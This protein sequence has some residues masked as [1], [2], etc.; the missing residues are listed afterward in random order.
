MRNMARSVTDWL[1]A[2]AMISVLVGCAPKDSDEKTTDSSVA[3][4][5][6][7]DVARSAKIPVTSA[8]DE[9]RSLYVKGRDLSE[10]LRNQDA[11]PLFEQAVAKD[12]TFALAHYNLALTAPT[13]K[14]FL[15]HLGQAVA[16][17]SKASEGE[18][19]LIRSLEAQ[20]KADPAKS[21]QLREEMVA[22]YPQDERAH[23]NLGNTYNGRQQYDKAV[24]EYRKAIELN[25]NFSPAY[26]SLGYTYRP[27]GNNTEAEQA[28]R[29]YIELVPNDPNPYDS[30]AELLMK[31]GRFDESIAQYR[32]A[33]SIDPRFGA[34]QIGIASN[35][36]LQG[37]H[38][39]AIAEAQKL[40][41]AARDDGD[42]RTAM[43]T[44]V[45]IDVDRGRT[46]QALQRMERLYALGA[47]SADT[48][49][50]ANDAAAIG[51][52]L[53]DA[54][55]TAEAQK[56]YAQSLAL[57]TAS[58]FPA[59]VKEDARL[60]DHF[61]KARVALA[62]NDLE[63][64]KAEADAYLKGSEAKQ[65]E[66]RVRGAHELAGLIAQKEKKFDEAIAHYGKGNQQ[67]PFVI[68][69][70]AL[71]HQGKG[72]GAKAKELSQ[73]AANDNSLPGLNYAFV[74]TKARNL[75]R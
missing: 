55:R 39:E 4:A 71:A 15:E 44:Q 21:L 26:N 31:M 69:Q 16:H 11:R 30:Y 24:A 60:G 35:L 23:F 37:K 50:M 19:L 1:P 67:D 8:S 41:D 36:M 34:S 32:K 59:E 51:D 25:P 10:Q 53:L 40:H 49:A 6:G 12:S 14:E 54:G 7:G 43:F 29:K 42:R 73:R 9:A 75:A 3:T 33:L 57:I 38:D 64:A 22:K 46:A 28:F 13:T 61:N 63:T 20:A 58:G 66:F 56:R 68:Y 5:A 62:T 2:V 45:V 74:R 65:N 18:Q 47:K 72:D 52:I 70:T 48:G 27:M 17:S